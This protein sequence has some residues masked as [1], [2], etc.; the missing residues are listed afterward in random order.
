V[1]ATD[2][3]KQQYLRS[4]YWVLASEAEAYL[5]IGNDTDAEQAY[6]TAYAIAPEAW[7]V[8]TTQEQREKLD[9]LLAI[10]PLKYIQAAG[11]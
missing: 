11:D 9:S 10:T 1:E 8:K 5:G 6:Q 7:M 2:A 4:K 3:A